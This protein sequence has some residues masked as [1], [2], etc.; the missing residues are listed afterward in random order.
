MKLVRLKVNFNNSIAETN[1]RL[2]KKKNYR[3]KTYK[4]SGNSISSLEI[5]RPFYN[6]GGPGIGVPTLFAPS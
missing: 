1:T 6:L 3:L 2:I 5:V 4:L